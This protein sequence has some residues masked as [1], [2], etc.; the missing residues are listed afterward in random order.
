MQEIQNTSYSHFHDEELRNAWL[1]NLGKT[2]KHFSD[3]ATTNIYVDDGK[4]IVVPITPKGTRKMLFKMGGA[5]LGGLVGLLAADAV[6]GKV[7]KSDEVDT[8]EVLYWDLSEAAIECWEE[9]DSEYDT[10]YSIKGRCSLGDFTKVCEI[11]FRQSGCAN[12]RSFL[13]T[14]NKDYAETCRILGIKENR[15]LVEMKQ[16]MRGN[17]KPVTSLFDKLF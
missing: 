3:Y 9:K 14:K 2:G 6:A 4:L 12:S 11:T 7:F 8:V 1:K 16:D 13:N 5:V 15:N 17:R 10:Y